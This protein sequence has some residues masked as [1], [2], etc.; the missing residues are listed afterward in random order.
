MSWNWIFR[1]LD[2]LLFWS[3]LFIKF[4]FRVYSKNYSLNYY[5]IIC[6]TI[7]FER[8]TNNMLTSSSGG[9]TDKQWK[10]VWTW[11][12]Q[13]LPTRRQHHGR[14]IRNSRLLSRRRKRQKR[15]HI[16]QES[17]VCLCHAS[18]LRSFD[19]VF[20]ISS[21]IRTVGY[22]NQGAHER[23]LEVY[24]GSSHLYARVYIPNLGCLHARFSLHK[25]HQFRPRRVQSHGHIHWRGRD[26]AI[27][28][29]NIWDA[30]LC[31]LRSHR[32]GEP[33][34]PLQST[35]VEYLPAKEHHWHLHVD[36]LHYARQPAHSHDVGHLCRHP[37]PV[38]HRVEVWKSQTLPEHEQNL[39]GPCA[40]H[41]C[42]ETHNLHHHS[43]SI[44]MW[45]S[46]WSCKCSKFI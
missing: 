7:L 38:W 1:D 31:P 10:P 19:G 35:V 5:I 18:V 17:V 6:Y 4:I 36:N 26:H 28:Q 37:G 41:S 27:A 30:F 44:Q 32:H 22:Y 42:H 24:R 23:P 39:I 29:I 12:A 33:T 43:P 40:D 45:E 2:G 9:A 25:R 13:T 46:N 3:N 16:H 8:C 14:R 34:V 21:P 11:L 20:V 15:S